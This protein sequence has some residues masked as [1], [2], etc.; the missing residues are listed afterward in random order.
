MVGGWINFSR[1][2]RLQV[3]GVIIKYHQPRSILGFFEP[4]CHSTKY[5][6]RVC[7]VSPLRNTFSDVSVPILEPGSI[8]GGNEERVFNYVGGN[9]RVC[10]M[11]NLP[12]SNLAINCN[13]VIFEK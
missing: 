7:E 1:L 10:K 5:F 2:I 6:S 3:F 12:S 11:E 8:A 4:H 13:E 9:K